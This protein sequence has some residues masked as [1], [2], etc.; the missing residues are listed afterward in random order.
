MA[1][2]AIGFSSNWHRLASA[3]GMSVPAELDLTNALD[4]NQDDLRLLY[5]AGLAAYVTICDLIRYAG[6]DDCVV[7]RWW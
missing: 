3:Q 2:A 1:N 7:W 5:G 6:C 4:K